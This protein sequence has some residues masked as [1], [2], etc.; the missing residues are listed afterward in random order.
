MH[1]R[2]PLPRLLRLHGML[3]RAAPEDGATLDYSFA[4]GLT[5]SYSSLRTSALALVAD[6]QMD[7]QEFEVECPTLA[8]VAPMGHP[9]PISITEYKV[10]AVKA[11]IRLRALRGYVEGLITMTVLTEDLSPSQ[12]ELVRTVV[13]QR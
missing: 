11:A 1:P 12:V 6:L 13:S 10:R 3:A 2:D 5:E 8:A 4:E 9:D 7:T